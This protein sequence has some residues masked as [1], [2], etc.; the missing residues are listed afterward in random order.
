MADRLLPDQTLTPDQRI[1]STNRKAALVMQG[2]GNFVLYQESTGKP[3]W[4]TGTNGRNGSKVIMQ[5]DGN[6]VVYS[7]EGPPIW[8]SRT[9]GNP[10]ASLVVQDD[11]NAVIYAADGRALWDS[12]TTLGALSVSNRWDHPNGKFKMRGNAYLT[13]EGQL[14]AEITAWTEDKWQGFT[15]GCIV[16]VIDAGDNVIHRQLFWPLGVDGEKIPF[17]KSLRAID[18][19]EEIGAALAARATRLEMWFSHMGKNRWD[20]ILGEISDKVADLKALY[21]NLSTNAR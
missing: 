15:G 4:A 1:E 6:L 16:S 20:D 10:G 9:T 8:D 13:T 19:I 21:E 11:G 14:R 12:G 5:G 2:D 17:K 18:P 7:P 3:L